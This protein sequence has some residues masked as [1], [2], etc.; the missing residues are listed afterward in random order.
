[1]TMSK[2][3]WP[4]S[5][6]LLSTSWPHIAYSRLTKAIRKFCFRGIHVKETRPDGEVKHDVGL[7]PWWKIKSAN[8]PILD[9]V[10]HA[11]LYISVLSSMPDCTFS[12]AGNT[13]TNKCNALKPNTL[14][15]L[16]YLHS[17]QDLYRSQ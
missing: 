3:R 17:N 7:L 8:F 13:R 16:L 4:S 1:M 14:N 11:I 5:R 12:F 15:T 2:V 10:A 6:P 9:R